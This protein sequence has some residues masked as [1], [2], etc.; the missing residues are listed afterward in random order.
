MSFTSLSKISI[1]LGGVRPVDPLLGLRPWT[2][3]GCTS[4]PQDTFPFASIHSSQSYRAVD[5]AGQ[6]SSLLLF[7]FSV[8][9]VQT[10]LIVA[11]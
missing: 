6:R 11:G 2:P 8:S 7:Y 3:T 4:V 10:P 5:A 1:S 9:I